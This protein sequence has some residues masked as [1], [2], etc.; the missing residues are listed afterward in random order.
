MDIDVR[1][2]RFG[3]A[4][5][6]LVLAVVL[7]TGSAWLLAWQTLAFALGAAGGVGRSPYGWLFRTLVR[8]RLGRP[9]EFES[10]EPPRFAQAV[11][12]AF[13]GVGLLGFTLGADWLGVAATGAALAAAF[14]NA[15]FGYCLGCEMYL[16][17][18]R[19]TVRAE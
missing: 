8:P 6:T 17:V 12:L 13:A 10:P 3:A 15:A 16:L 5:T 9:T 4:V 19:L 7:I 18:R 2:P 11:G 1:G 14:L